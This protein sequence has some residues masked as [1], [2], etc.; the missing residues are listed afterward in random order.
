M[1]LLGINVDRDGQSNPSTLRLAGA[2]WLRVVA[3]PGVNL[4]PWL[5]EVTRLGMKVLLVIA[6][7]SADG[8][9]LTWSGALSLWKMS[10]GPWVSAYQVMNEPDAGW[11][12]TERLSA[13]KRRESGQYP[14]SWVMDPDDVSERLRV[15]REVLG[16]DAFIVGPGLC[17]GHAEYADLVDWSPVSALA[18][19]PYAKWPETPEL[20]DMITA[21]RQRRPEIIATEYDS[22][23]PG[24]HRA[25]AEDVR[26][27][28]AITFCLTDA[29]VPDFG[30]IDADG[31]IKPSFTDFVQ[32]AGRPVDPVPVVLEYVLGFRQIADAHPHL[33]GEPRENE[34]GFA[35][36][37]SCQRTSGGFLLWAN[38]VE[39][40]Q[41]MG[42]I[43]ENGDRYR[44]NGG[45]LETVA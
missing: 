31:R 28:A 5:G 13:K 41:V 38:T 37:V 20:D 10:Y 42:F 21:Y 35:P 40:G 12:P 36:G 8:S 4:V 34:W 16:P 7:E 24:M 30:M 11:E 14:S 6:N 45:E 3:M 22:R 25:L 27:M 33:I 2:R 23:T 15:A 26:I 29:M 19:H 18:I 9:G 39:S 17:S 32:A 43:S 44:W 1:A